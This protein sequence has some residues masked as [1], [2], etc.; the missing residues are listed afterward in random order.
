MPLAALLAAC[1]PAVNPPEGY[2]PAAEAAPRPAPRSVPR[3][4]RDD[5]DDARADDA[6]QD[7]GA[8]HNG[9]PSRE[10][11][12]H[13]KDTAPTSVAQT[14]PAWI[15]RKVVADARTVPDQTY[16]VKPG[17]SLRGIAE[18]TGAGSEAI[19]RANHL[20]APFTVAPGRKLKIPGGRYHR[21]KEGETGIAIARAYGVDWA[22]I[23]ALNDLQEPYFLR[24]NQRLLIPSATEVAQMSVEDRAKA[25]HL[26]I[27]DLI[28]G[29]EPAIGDTGR[30]AKPTASARRTLP[31]EAV[32]A[33]PQHFAGRFA[34]PIE[35]HHVLTRFGSLGN[36]RRSD[37]I[38]IAAEKGEPIRAA[39]DGVVAYVGSEIAV[40]GG[41]ILIKHGQG[42]LTAYGH[43][44][45]LLVKRGQSVRQGEI[46][47]RAGD[48][49]D[50]SAPQLHFE[51]RRGR[52]PVDPLGQL[53]GG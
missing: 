36:G 30:P 17:D 21:V 12:E 5:A 49:G 48:T 19:A 45:A 23:V 6:R 11:N 52:T 10:Q 47:G 24:T 13:D 16:T 41:L 40:Y 14:T 51:I 42:W 27:D 35:G 33:P 4:S 44:D 46:I 1:I 53:P 28:T 50:V 22:K 34:W 7:S 31:P 9:G 2:G 39:A 37:G 15:A 43:A 38:N 3:A 32:V 25:F 29:A 26:D 8:R 20:D 18:K